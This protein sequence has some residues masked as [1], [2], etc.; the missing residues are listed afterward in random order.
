MH[1]LNQFI[2]NKR[3]NKS[4]TAGH[5]YLKNTVVKLFDIKKLVQNKPTSFLEK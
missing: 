1:Y 3:Q 5:L 2:K 4:K